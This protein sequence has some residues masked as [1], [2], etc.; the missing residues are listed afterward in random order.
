MSLTRYLL[1]FSICLVLFYGLYHFLLRKET[2]FQLNRWYLLLSPLLS[3][4]IPFIRVELP[5]EPQPNNWSEV[6]F[7]LVTDLQSG[8][9]FIWAN[10]NSP[11]VRA[12]SFTYL[13]LLLLI[14]MIGVVA[15]GYRLLGR[16]WTLMRLIG[17]GKQETKAGYTV[18]HTKRR[19]PAASFLSYVFWE[20][21]P[22]DPD[23][24]KILEHELVH[25]RQWHTLDVLLMEIWV[26]FKWFHPLIYWYRKSLRLTHEYIADAYVSD[27]S[28][29][30][31]AYAQ[32][33][34]HA[35]PS[36]IGNHLLHQFNS[37][38]KMRL[39]MLSKHQ[40][41]K[42]KYLKYL[43]I[44]PVTGVL[45]LLF[46]LNRSEPVIDTLDRAETALNNVVHQTVDLEEIKVI[47][48]D[49]NAISSTFLGDKKNYQLEWGALTCDCYQ[50]EY[51]NL[52]NCEA[53]TFF[54]EGL[55]RIIQDKGGF[56]LTLDGA[57]QHMFDLTAVSKS[58]KD[59][60]GYQGQFD[61]MGKV[62][63]TNSPLW[64]QAEV[65]DV[66]RFTFR[67]GQKDHFQFEVLV[68]DA[69]QNYSLGERLVIGNKAYELKKFSTHFESSKRGGLVEMSVDEFRQLLHEPLRMQKDDRSYYK[70]KWI[71]LINLNAMRS[72]TREKINQE[73]VPLNRMMSILD[74]EPGDE[75][76]FRMDA[77][78]GESVSFAIRIKDEPGFR[79]DAGRKV[80]VQWGDLIMEKNQSMVL[81][82]EEIDKLLYQDMYLLYKGKH[83]V[84]EEAK[85]NSFYFTSNKEINPIQ[86]QE[87]FREIMKRVKP[88][89]SITM[90]GM[91]TEG[92]YVVPGFK[93]YIDF[94]WREVFIDHSDAVF[95]KD[96][97]SV[98]IPNASPNDLLRVMAMGKFPL[99]AYV[100]EVDGVEYGADSNPLPLSETLME[101]MEN[102]LPRESLKI[103][104]KKF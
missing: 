21:G 74:A 53:K 100:I 25:V 72:D 103:S 99:E 80:Q 51:P 24:K 64:D 44:G 62:F 75:I 87:V 23:R 37:S 76:R 82:K 50:G 27:A 49:Q 5:A 1:E 33:L 57:P 69:D 93:I 42:W 7:P 16:T 71:T 83:K 28:G 10:L 91:I 97:S 96:G 58:M 18:V 68:S 78:D 15:M 6:V 90:G 39:L 70:I 13:D 48:W 35:R 30:R 79:S 101:L 59:M 36:G 31:L 73:E 34:A 52:Y 14:Y 19:L 4:I 12:W 77:V 88:G 67:N 45:F 89:E 47:G 26:M 63:R 9:E 98:M 32:L 55:R 65:G 104:R 43:F 102:E 20:E 94:N 61:E 11:P 46:S 2:F 22:L 60:G 17:E 81:S 41:E 66:F 40:S 38:K 86:Y 92:D 56:K 84:L 8:Q 54:P 29:S 95:A 3:M 85:M